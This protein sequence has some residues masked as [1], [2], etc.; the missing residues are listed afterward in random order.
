MTGAKGYLRPTCL[1]FPL[2]N[3]QAFFEGNADAWFLAE[4]QQDI[5]W[6]VLGV[7]SEPIINCRGLNVA[8]QRYV[9]LESYHG[10]HKRGWD[11]FDPDTT[12]DGLDHALIT[13]DRQKA[14]YIW[15]DLLP[16]LIRFLR[17]RYQTATHQNYDNATTHED[18]SKLCKTLKEKAWIPIG[19]AEFKRP[20]ECTVADMAG[21]LKRNEELAR[22]LGI[23]PDPAIVAVEKHS[24]RKSLVTQAG[25]APEVAALLVRHSDILTIDLIT[26]IVDARGQRQSN[27]PEFPERPVPNKVRRARTVGKR[28]R[29]ADPKTYDERKRSVRT[30]R[31]R[32]SPKVWLREMYTNTRDVTVCQMCR[33]GMPFRVPKTGEYYFEAVQLA[34]NFSAEDHCLYLALCPLCSAKY[35]V[36]VKTNEDCLSDF[37]GA[38]ERAE[39][40]DYEIPIKLNGRPASV[41]F[42]EA[43]M[44]DLKAA[45]AECLS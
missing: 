1:S 35:T 4:S 7:R 25:F 22:I 34:D 39:P 43:H 10:W 33:R 26:E 15:N 8:R 44:L 40:N 2:A 41:R 6:S 31:P 42:V 5:C 13:I 45:L 18:D 24:A 12:I 37:V 21:D 3:L 19:D 36:L 20:K 38:I 27:S 32:Q 14:A 9:K 29:K 17:G 30:S 11:G 16:P 23:Q 28:V